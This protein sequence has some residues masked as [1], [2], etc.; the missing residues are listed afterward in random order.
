[1][2]G[3]QPTC[4]TMCQSGVTLSSFPTLCQTV[5]EAGSCQ[6]ACQNA[7]QD[8]CEMGCQF[9][10]E[11]QPNPCASCEMMCVTDCQS[12]EEQ[13]SMPGYRPTHVPEGLAA[14]ILIRA[15]NLIVITFAQQ[16]GGVKFDDFVIRLEHWLPP[17]TTPPPGS[18]TDTLTDVVKRRV[19]RQFVPVLF[20]VR[21]VGTGRWS[22]GPCKAEITWNEAYP[23]LK[24][25]SEQ[26]LSLID[27]M[28][29]QITALALKRLEPGFVPF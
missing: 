9:P 26:R 12:A 19:D 2:N 5:C 25:M 7:C 1:M 20:S 13:N 11:A 28:A 21:Y 14:K 16:E 18:N 29:S 4:Q 24:A 8:A 3:S 6:N 17:L 22:D 10:M 27:C 23:D 15:Q